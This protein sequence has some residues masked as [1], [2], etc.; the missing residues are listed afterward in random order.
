MRKHISLTIV[1][2]ILSLLLLASCLG[3]NITETV[4]QFQTQTVTLPPVTETITTQPSIT[5]T[6]FS[7][8]TFTGSKVD[9]ETLPFI[10][11]TN[12]WI[13]DWSYVPQRKYRPYA[14]FR[15]FVYPRD[16]TDV[17]IESVILPSGYS[18]TIFSCAGVGEYYLDVTAIRVESW[19]ITIRPS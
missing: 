12:E 6:T 14:D 5:E 15:F 4:T 7:P 3:T 11:T 19:R 13:I 8:I 2:I 18:G 1:L 10:V 16:K 9:K 17:Y